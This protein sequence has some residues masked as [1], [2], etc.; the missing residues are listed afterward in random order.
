MPAAFAPRSLAS[1]RPEQVCRA[2]CPERDNLSCEVAF[3]PPNR[4]TF[5]RDWGV[6]RSGRFDAHARISRIRGTCISTRV[7]RG[8]LSDVAMSARTST[9]TVTVVSRNRE[10][11]DGLQAYLAR[12]GVASRARRT[13]PMPSGSEPRGD[14]VIIFPDELEATDVPAYIAALHEARPGIVAV[15]V[16]REPQRFR[17]ACT[18]GSEHAETVVLPRPAFAWTILDAIRTRS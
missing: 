1:S 14:A 16:T 18:E 9:T 4:P 8:L 11:V 7:A 2:R 13:L 17:A 12:A 3:E 5:T 10:T 6:E 15:V